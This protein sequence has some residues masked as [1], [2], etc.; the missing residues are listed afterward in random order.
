MTFNI[1][2]TNNLP[3]IIQRRDG[4]QGS[5]HSVQILSVSKNFVDKLLPVL[6]FGCLERERGRWEYIADP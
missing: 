5:K 4:N 2:K 6:T 3:K 1:F